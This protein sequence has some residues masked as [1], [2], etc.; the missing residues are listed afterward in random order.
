MIV[1]ITGLVDRYESVCVC[2]HTLMQ[3]SSADKEFTFKKSYTQYPEL[4][5]GKL[6]NAKQTPQ[7]SKVK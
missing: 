6:W 3:W 5:I 1:G 4:V 7:K 2:V